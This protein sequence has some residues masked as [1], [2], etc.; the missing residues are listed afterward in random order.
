MLY[1][2]ICHY[3]IPSFRF[4]TIVETGF[5]LLQGTFKLALVDNGQTFLSGTLQL[6]DDQSFPIPKVTGRIPMNGFVTTMI[7]CGDYVNYM[8]TKFYHLS[9]IGVNF[10]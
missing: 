3:K 6:A 4:D 10:D 5:K 7:D 8:L 2:S 1:T 9:V